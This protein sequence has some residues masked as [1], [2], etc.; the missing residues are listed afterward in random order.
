MDHEGGNIT[1]TV[2]QGKDFRTTSCGKVLHSSGAV[3]EL[4]GSAGLLHNKEREA[5]ND[6]TLPKNGFVDTLHMDTTDVEIVHRSTW[7]CDAGTRKMN[8]GLQGANKGRIA[9]LLK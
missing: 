9:D 1:C 4:H 7:K 3:Y 5:T 2:L 8:I 6:I